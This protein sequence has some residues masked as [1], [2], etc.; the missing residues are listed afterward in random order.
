MTGLLFGETMRSMSV[1]A[2][3]LR[4]TAPGYGECIM[5]TLHGDDGQFSGIRIDRAD[6]VVR[7]SP[8]L[9]ASLPEPPSDWPATYD[10]KVL[11]IEGVNQTVVY[12]IRDILEPVPGYPG[13]WD[14]IGEWPD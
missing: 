5:T 14:Y 12:R 13:I 11:R 7:I 2:L 3:S 9:V 8:E 1:A 6:P 10:G 4:L